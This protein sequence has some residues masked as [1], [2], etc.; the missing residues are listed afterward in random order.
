MIAGNVWKSGVLL[1]FSK[2]CELVFNDLLYFELFTDG[3][4]NDNVNRPG[5]S[6]AAVL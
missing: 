2:Y 4:F 1:L 5:R 6:L 3:L